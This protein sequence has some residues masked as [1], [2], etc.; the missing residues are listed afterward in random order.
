MAD[1]LNDL[2]PQPDL[3]QQAIDRAMPIKDMQQKRNADTFNQPIP[4]QSFTTEPG[5]FA[6]EQP[7]QFTKLSD[8]TNYMFDRITSPSVQRDILRLLDAGVPVATLLEPILLH[9]V[10]KGKFNLDA[11]LLAAEP[12]ATMITGLGL[13]AGINVVAAIKKK[14]DGVDPRPFAKAFKQ[15]SEAENMEPITK[16]KAAS[17]VK[18][19]LLSREVE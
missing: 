3:F 18:N 16:D 13:R 5:T 4:G 2:A 8:I 6:Y 9:G 14:D 19:S 10:N 11:A 1:L 7:P 12:V 15:K 17:M